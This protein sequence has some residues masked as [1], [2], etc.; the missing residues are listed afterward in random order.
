MEEKGG[1]V[2]KPEEK[3]CG[4]SSTSLVPHSTVCRLSVC[5]PISWSPY[6]HTGTINVSILQMGKMKP[7]IQSSLGLP[8]FRRFSLHQLRT[9]CPVRD[10]PAVGDA[11]EVSVLSAGLQA[12]LRARWSCQLCPTAVFC[13]IE[14]SQRPST[15]LPS[16]HPYPRILPIIQQFHYLKRTELGFYKLLQKS[17]TTSNSTLQLVLLRN[18]HWGT[19]AEPSRTWT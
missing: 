8:V 15:L 4:F 12:S 2:A 19:G 5:I 17:D 18:N 16:L 11:A 7:E 9:H 1:Q 6:I 10:R 13:G 14:G 3:G